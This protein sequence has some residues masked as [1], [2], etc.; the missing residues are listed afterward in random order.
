MKTLNHAIARRTIHGRNTD[1]TYVRYV[2]AM[3]V[4]SLLVV[5]SSALAVAGGEPV[6]SRKIDV[7][8]AEGDHA[9]VTVAVRDTA[10]P[11]PAR[12]SALRVLVNLRRDAAHPVDT[13]CG[14]RDLLSTRGPLGAGT[15]TVRIES[16]TLSWRSG[17]IR[18]V[19]PRDSRWTTNRRRSSRA[20]CPDHWSSS[21]LSATGSPRC[22]SVQ[23]TDTCELQSA[24]S[25]DLAQRLS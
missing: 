16:S 7:V 6:V 10:H 23:D 24:S 22:A 12:V 8:A 14:A 15:H 25:G 11:L 3:R 2:R 4:P 21:R 1:V 13:R 19:D 17:S 18:P 5:I 9:I 20:A